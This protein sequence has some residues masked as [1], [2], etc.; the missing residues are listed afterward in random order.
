MA[1]SSGARLG[2][3]EILGPLGAGGMGEVYRA[4][5]SKLDRTVA[6]KVLPGHL[7]ADADA[8]MRFEREAKAVAALSHPNI[9]AIFDFGTYEGVT[10]AGMEMLEGESLR[11]RLAGGPLPPRK[12]V[13]YALQICQALAAAHEKGIVHRDLKPENVF[14]TKDG[15]IKVLD[16]GLA[17]VVPTRAPHERETMDLTPATEA[18]TVLGTVGYMSP[19]QVRG[20][21]V[22]QRSDIFS[23]G[24]IFY[25]M[26]SGRRAFKA[27]SPV[28]T[29]SAI[30]KDD[31]PDLVEANRSLS[32][33][34]ERVVRH[35]LEKSR[36]ERFQ[37][38]RDLAF[39]LEALAGSSSSSGSGAAL[40]GPPSPSR[41][42][43]LVLP[44]GLLATLGMGLVLGRLT[45][46][47]PAALSF[48]QVTFR[49]G[50]VS[51]ARFAPDGDTIVYSAAWDGAPVQ[52]FTTHPERP[53]SRSL[54]LASSGVFAVSSSG[55]MAIAVQ[56]QLFWGGCH[57][58]LSRV[59]M[60]GGSPR[61]LLEDV[62]E[63][64]WTPD[65]K[66]LAIVHDVGERHRLEFPSGH[67][68]YETSGWI[69]NVRFS[70]RGDLI[71]FIDHRSTA[72]DSGSVA[73]VDRAGVYRALSTGWGSAWGLAWSASGS[74]VWFTAA[75]MGRL[76]SL[77]AVSL[78]GEQ[79]V[80]LRAPARLLLHDISPEGRVLLTR[81]TART[82]LLA[83]APGATEE[84]DLSWFDGSVVTD[85]SRDGRMVLFCERGEGARAAATAYLRATDGS[86][87][88]KLGEGRPLALSPDGSEALTVPEGSPETLVLLPTGPGESRHLPPGP[89]T[90][91]SRATFFPSGERILILGSERGHERRCYVQD[92]EG[93]PPR[94]V[95]PEGPSVEFVGCPISAD[96]RSFA[97]RGPEG[98]VTVY[99]VEP[100]ASRPLLGARAGDVPLGWSEDGQAILVWPR[101]QLPARVYRID[102]AKGGRSLFKELRP[103]EGAGIVGILTLDM[104]PDGSSYAYTSDHRHAELFLT[105]GLR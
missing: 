46:K 5:D 57:G 8:L 88:V 21:E 59:P 93:G 104:A 15:R 13:E 105:E 35:C 6:I 9:L 37:S 4:R 44:L 10:V 36:E 25:E 45:L 68:L 50:S 99:P 20:Q 82:G 101:E 103:T 86:P 30:L 92:L 76:Q 33:A 75:E 80:V 19:E 77:H 56:C 54:D 17:K 22:D 51:G 11:A 67:V 102:V 60:E 95:S 31:P 32:P 41:F 66:D 89:L 7:I 84:R 29:M 73:V 26:L 24:S 49:R 78:Q 62:H 34:F 64:D 42:R 70:R 52:I 98:K 40:P 61:E 96:G 18:G 91:Y 1:L 47:P 97:A 85:L 12:A 90:S 53:E 55:E 87:A 74:E 39:Q 71:A 28:E 14:V 38:A 2:P 23:F 16:F 100:G 81:E 83:R 58:I 63:A 69:S 79:R 72:D 65:G 3:Y 27:D 48:R 94:P 43:S